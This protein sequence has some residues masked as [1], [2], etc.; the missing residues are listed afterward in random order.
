M[1][2]VN[3]SR[4][5]ASPEIEAKRQFQ[6]AVSLARADAVG[7]K[8]RNENRPTHFRGDLLLGAVLVKITPCNGQTF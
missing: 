2:R 5:L 1:V 6:P 3:P 8:P 4:T 7:L